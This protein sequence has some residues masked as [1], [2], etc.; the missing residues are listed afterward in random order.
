MK[1]RELTGNKMF[2]MV[3]EECERVLG[4]VDNKPVVKKKE[5]G[6]LFRDS[7]SIWKKVGGKRWF[8]SGDEKTQGK[9]EGEI[10][11]GVPDGIGTLTWSDGEKYEG[12][13]K[14][15]FP[16]GQ[17][18]MTFP[19]G[20]KYIGEH[21]DGEYNGQGTYTY[22]NGDKYIGEFKDGEYHGQ[23]TMT[24]PDG[25]KFVGE[26]KDGKLWNGTGYD[27]NGNIFVKIVNGKDIKP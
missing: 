2:E 26:F 9:Y 7:N 3:K 24:Y 19:D 13:Y 25:D 21:K 10:M 23:G 4:K 20:D 22:P 12:E 27:K 18:T 5:K 16:N 6:I 15:G 14:D 8:K 1:E 11:N 17:G